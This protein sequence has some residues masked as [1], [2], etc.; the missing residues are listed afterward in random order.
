MRAKEMVR[1]FRA[2]RVIRGYTFPGLVLLTFVS[3]AEITPRNA[4]A[5]TVPGSFSKQCSYEPERSKHLS[6]RHL[7]CSGPGGPA[8]LRREI[9]L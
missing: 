2:V 1:G 7:D 3:L 9:S 8:T 5:K 6:N 4:I